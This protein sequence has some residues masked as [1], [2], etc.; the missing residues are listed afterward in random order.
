MSDGTVDRGTRK[1]VTVLFSDITRSTTLGRDL[2]PESLQHLLSRYFG[3][4]QRVVERHGGTVEKFIG[5]AV[6]AVFGLRRAHEDDALR[7]V[8]AAVEMREALAVLNEE[9]VSTWGVT[10]AV[11]TGVNTGEVLAR[12]PDGDQA[13]VVGDAVNIAARLEQ[14]AQPGEILIGEETYRMVGDGGARR[15]G[16]PAGAA[17]HHP[18]ASPWRL[19]EV[20]A[21]A[22]GRSRRLDS[23]L[24]DR[25]RELAQ[26]EEAFE[27]VASRPACELVTVLAPAG[28]GK[29][30]L[31]AELVARVGLASHTA[32]TLP[33]VRRGDHLL[34]T[35][36]RPQRRPGDRG[37][38]RRG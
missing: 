32:G 20:I 18:A 11:R 19:F 15:T 9:F 30:R 28:A 26:L 27:R 31:T 34:A 23:P 2:D 5:D 37:P 22:Q 33:S 16:R 12:D 10:V 29:S 21:H 4:M 6:M 13:L 38:R 3:D 35:R 17:W 36:L 14:V 8:R 25:T 7:A 1:V 24:V